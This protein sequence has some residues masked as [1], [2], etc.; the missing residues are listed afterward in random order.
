MNQP[1]EIEKA[2]RSG[3]GTNG[4][5]FGSVRR[6]NTPLSLNRGIKTTPKAPRPNRPIQLRWILLLVYIVVGGVLLGQCVLH[7]GHSPYCQYAFYLMLPAG[8][9][10][11]A[12]LNALIPW[13]VIPQSFSM[14]MPDSKG[15]LCERRTSF[16]LFNR[17]EDY[18]SFR[19]SHDVGVKA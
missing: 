12:L 4:S 5:A 11:A 18:V 8:P 1:Y 15:G 14:S 13:S 2:F 6:I 19:A 7:I 3:A 10:S 17:S 16:A 9:A